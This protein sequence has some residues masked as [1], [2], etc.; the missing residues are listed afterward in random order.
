V[1]ATGRVRDLLNGWT[2]RELTF[3]GTVEELLKSLI[4]RDAVS[5]FEVMVDENGIRQETK[6]T[7]GL[8]GYSITWFRG[9]S[10][11]SHL[12]TRNELNRVRL[13]DGDRIW[14]T[15]IPPVIVGG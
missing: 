14:L 11:P 9:D 2:K 3:E 15:D 12:E 1:I 13:Q 5:L 6:S 7:A 8:A 4:T 10:G